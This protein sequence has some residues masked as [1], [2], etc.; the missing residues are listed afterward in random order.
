MIE[1]TQESIAEILDAIGPFKFHIWHQ[2]NYSGEHREWKEEYT[3]PKNGSLTEQIVRAAYP[4]IAQ[5]A[6]AWQIER[7]AQSLDDRREKLMARERPD[8]FPEEH[9]KHRQ[10]GIENVLASAAIALRNQKG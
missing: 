1:V 9:W 10:A 4:L 5:A 3:E 7:D 2:E 8:D 6:I